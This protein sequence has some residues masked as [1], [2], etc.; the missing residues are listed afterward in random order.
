MV[1]LVCG[2]D[3]AVMV[4]V[5]DWD[6]VVGV[7]FVVVMLLVMMFVVVVCGCDV[8]VIVVVCV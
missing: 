2:C 8:V 6:V 5:C 4:V 3:V 7:F 1:V